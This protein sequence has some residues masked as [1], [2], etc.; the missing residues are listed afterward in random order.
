MAVYSEKYLTTLLSGATDPENDPVSIYRINNAIINSWPHSVS[1]TEGSVFVHQTGV[2]EYDDG[3]SSGGHPA[4]GQ[5]A[6]VGT[7]SFTI[8]DGQD[9][10]PEYTANIQ[11]SGLTNAGYTPT[12]PTDFGALTRAGD[13]G[14][15]LPA[16]ET[17][18]ANAGGT[19]LTVSGGFVVPSS[20]GV[21]AGTVTFGNGTTWDITTSP[22]AYSVRSESELA[23]LMS[24]PGAGVLSGKTVMMRAGVYS[25]QSS[26]FNYQAFSSLT[27]FRPHGT[28]DEVTLQFAASSELRAAKNMCWQGL[29]L[30]FPYTIGVDQAG[31]YAKG[32]IFKNGVDNFQ[33]KDGRI[34][35]NLL[36][37]IQA[38]GFPVYGTDWTWRG[39]LAFESGSN[40]G[41]G[42]LTL[43]DNKIHGSWRLLNITGDYG[44][45]VI[46]GNEF[47]DFGV[48]AIIVA[49]ERNGGLDLNWNKFHSTLAFKST[50][51]NVLSVN[52]SSNTITLAD[53]SFLGTVGS[54]LVV[55]FTSGT[56]PSPL[57]LNQ[58]IQA[59]ISSST[60]V[61]LGTNITSSGSGA[62]KIKREEAHA[63]FIQFIAKNNAGNA[64]VTWTGGNVIGNRFLAARSDALQSV[65]D[66]ASQCIFMQDI[67][68][69]DQDDNDHY[70]NMVIAGNLMWSSHA[71]GISLYNPRNSRIEHNTC[72]APIGTSYGALPRTRILLQFAGTGGGNA[73]N[74]NL[75]KQ[76]AYQ[77][78]LSG[79]LLNNRNIDVTNGVEASNYADIFVNPGTPTDIDDLTARFAIKPGG[80]ADVVSPKQGAHPHVDYINRI[81][82]PPS[83]G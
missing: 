76:S 18:I 8:W 81:Y 56:P 58:D 60:T 34:R 40:I 77:S 5:V 24:S 31:T 62:I 22:N 28:L 45:V 10:S 42:G 11:L 12:G 1:L 25:Y 26:T 2:V 44:P 52:P 69:T 57:G 53:T 54:G 21:T 46:E 74:G 82:T 9:E 43:T 48:D 30:Y 16:G 23:G 73:I 29:D 68:G 83:Y 14:I 50:E 65:V 32:L 6:A 19:N 78:P 33:V 39:M 55:N 17:T 79:T 37:L 61:T 64:N 35:G 63:D 20:N 70:E 4:P 3:G 59:T 80:P 27:T 36:E 47:Y 15:G 38:N 13:G 49:G 51:G 71:H 41:A 72:V 66:N 67:N 75:S 7:F